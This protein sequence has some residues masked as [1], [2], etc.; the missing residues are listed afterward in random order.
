MVAT[1]N[2]SATQSAIINE[3]TLTEALPMRLKSIKLAGFK[4][5]VDPTKVELLSNRVAIV[6]PNGCGKSNII[7]AVR[8]VMGE[9]SAKQ[10]RGESLVDVIFN[11][12]T[13]RPPI[14]Q[15]SIELHFDNSDG[16]LGGAYASYAEIVIRRQVTRDGQSTY[17]L[18]GSRCRRKDV[19]DIFLGTGLGP[20]SYAIIEQGTISRLI[21]AKPDDLRI[22]LEEAAGISKYKERRKETELRLGHT[23]DNL[24]RLSDITEELSKQ[25]QHLDRQAK[26]AE[27]FKQLK[28]DER[29]LKAQLLILRSELLQ[30][31][32][33]EKHRTIDQEQDQ[34]SH[35]QSQVALL[36]AGNSERLDQQDSAQQA[37]TSIQQRYMEQGAH[38]ARLEQSIQHAELRYQQVTDELRLL[39]EQMAQAESL[40]TRDETRLLALTE[41]LQRLEPTFNEQNLTLEL[42]SEQLQLHEQQTQHS[43]THWDQLNQ[44]LFK[45]S[46]VAQQKQHELQ[47]LE[48]QHQ[49]VL[50]QQQQWLAEQQQLEQ[51]RQDL[52]QN[53]HDTELQ[54]LQEQ[55]YGA[56][57]I[58][59]DTT[60][61]I[62]T[63][64]SECEQARATVQQWQQQ[65]TAQ[66]AQL[67]G[68][69]TYQAQALKRASA[70]SPKDLT[71]LGIET[72]QPLI[73]LLD[74]EPGYEKAVET[75]LAHWLQALCVPTLTSVI[76]LMPGPHKQPLWLVELNASSAQPCHSLN[77]IQPL[78]SKVRGPQAIL[79]LLTHVYLID[80]LPDTTTEYDP[81]ITFIT[82][83]GLRLNAGLLQVG[84][85]AEEGVLERQRHIQTLFSQIDATTD[86]LAQAQAAFAESELCLSQLEQNRVLYQQEWQQINQRF[87]QQQSVV[88]IRLAK[89]QQLHDRVQSLAQQISQATEKAEALWLSH[90][91]LR[92]TWQ[93]ALRELE[94]LT[95]QKEQLSSEREQQ[96]DHLQQCR[97]QW[98][99]QQHQ[100][101]RLKLEQQQC[102][103][104]KNALQ[105][106]ITRTTDQIA[107]FKQRHSALIQ[108]QDEVQEP[109]PLWQQQLETL[110]E[111]RFS[112]EMALQEAKIRVQTL[113]ESFRASEL[114]RRESEQQVDAQRLKLETARLAAEALLTRWQQLQEQMQ[115][116]P[117]HAEQSTLALTMEHVSES[118][119]QQQLAD[120]SQKIQ[121]LGLVNLAAIEEFTVQTARKEHLDQQHQDL[122]DAMAILENAIRTI[123]RETKA[124]FQETF[125]QVNQNF[126]KLFPQVFVGGKAYLELTGD[127]LLSTGVMVFAQPPGKRNS[128]IHLLS[129]GEKALTAVA[130]VFAIFQINPAPFCMLDEVDAPL[131]DTNV[132]RFCQLVNA[133]ADKTQFIMVTHN[134]VAME[135]AD[136]LMGV[137]MQ[138]PGVSRLVAVDMNAALAMVH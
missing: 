63:S 70:M 138:E 51:T 25:I 80:A 46:G 53:N 137:T 134:K 64:R 72:A 128:T 83:E 7:D 111:T 120:T 110:I 66:Q 23:R 57:Q 67:K 124:R 104:E 84:Q 10:L 36:E 21:E 118:V 31:E 50:Q 1:Q 123:D 125:E 135:M 52:S 65:L 59:S 5:F 55:V 129:G 109:L 15:A 76:A 48:Q 91:S 29:L 56:E 113:A 6:G 33:T 14:S 8:W 40:A 13:H 122:I 107:Q 97:S 101:H 95:Q 93:T 98:Q 32:L 105:Q 60:C 121:R 19:T 74:V 58:L 75:I 133:M 96:R 102:Q 27:R 106:Q 132:T 117:E 88:Q 92:D 126:Q 79:N 103:T 99:A 39:S 68:L 116:S 119:L 11:G 81:A 131:D 112:E 73:A 115:A 3:L 69:E 22:F 47:K 61:A 44:T 130:L 4:S 41:S 108:S 86:R 71:A 42:L 2:L 77:G 78:A 26:A 16:T 37:L 18:N 12:S 90:E 24:A 136:Q 82:P 94:T 89:Q 49:H 127:D 38:V 62:E 54:L 20:R 34:L 28:A 45:A 35:L 114:Q 9:S 100:V 43:Q 85:P 87:H 30:Q 17:T